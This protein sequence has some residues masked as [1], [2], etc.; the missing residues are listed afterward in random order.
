MDKCYYH[1]KT[2]AVT[3]C[4][5]CKMP[6]CATC[7]DEGA[8]GL[9][10]QCV[11]KQASLSEPV[12]SAKPGAQ[13]PGRS[14]AA[15]ARRAAA[16]A[17]GAAGVRPGSNPRSDVGDCFRHDD[18]RAENA[19]LTCKRAYCPACL[20]TSGVCGVCARI[21]KDAQARAFGLNDRGRAVLAEAEAEKAAKRLKPRDYAVVAVLIVGLG[22]S[23]KAMNPKQVK[24]DETRETLAR[25]KTSQITPEQ[26]AL[27]DSL[28]SQ[29]RVALKVPEPA[30]A[31]GS[32]GGAAAGG[33]YAAPAQAPAAYAGGGAAAVAEALEIRAVAPADGAI[34][35]GTT[36]I[37]AAV[38]G[39]P[40]RVVC[41]VDGSVVGTSA[42]GAPRFSWN[43][44]AAGNGSHSVTITAFNAAGSTSTSFT[45]NV[46]NR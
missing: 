31:A 12:R 3:S 25:V 10:D 40:S 26:Q 15:G 42:G 11:R 16:G 19:C 6:V 20:N 36:S 41:E 34:V 32:A 8:K 43:T 24:V 18:I 28:K 9:C 37:R 22:V 21:N 27:L 45:L 2:A 17:P 7:R 14:A 13:A 38:A 4:I 39:N 23:Y 30:Q 35:G 5:G 44:R 46:L 33:G 1:A 29:K